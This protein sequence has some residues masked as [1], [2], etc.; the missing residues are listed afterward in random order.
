MLSAKQ[1]P[2]IPFLV[3]RFKR[4][5]IVTHFGRE[6]E[7]NDMALAGVRSVRRTIEILD[8][9]GPDARFALLPLLEDPDWS[10]R[11]FAAGYLVKAAPHRALPV[12]KEISEQCLTEARISASD[13]L[14]RHKRGE[15]QM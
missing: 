7:D 6:D 11:V 10:I 1:D 4:G 12:L 5:A 8:V 13:M 2:M 3:E 14:W 9:F 15:L